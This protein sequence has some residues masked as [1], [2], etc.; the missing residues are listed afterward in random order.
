M[1]RVSPML[2]IPLAISAGLVAMF[3][4]GMQRGNPEDLPSALIGKP[5]PE[6]TAE[7][8]PGH[9]GVTPASLASG[10]V[11]VV[12]FW[13]S[14]CPPCRAEHPNL[15][16]LAA[17]GVDLVGVN[18]GD[19]APDATK[20]L[21][22]NGNPFSHLAFDPR[23]RTA[24]DWGVAAPPETFILDGTGKVVFKFIGPMV[25]DDFRQRFLP[26]LRKAQDKA[27]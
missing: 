6:V 25:G 22:D 17:E 23:R 9:A 16:Q 8:L 24:V 2:L 21:S 15:M 12:N 4:V 11:V 18:F 26:A 5:A 1:A 3:L 10:H 14:W 7:G 27:G 13:A 19:Q 20:Y